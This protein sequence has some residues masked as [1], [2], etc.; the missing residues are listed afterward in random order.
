MHPCFRLEVEFVS[1][2]FSKSLC[3]LA[4]PVDF[5]SENLVWLPTFIN[6]HR[7]FD[8]ANRFMRF[9]RFFSNMTCFLWK[10]SRFDDFS[11]RRVQDSN[12][13]AFLGASGL[14][15]RRNRP[16]LPTLHWCGADSRTRTENFR[17]T[18]AI[19]YHWV[20]SATEDFLEP[21]GGFEPSKPKHWFTKPDL[22]T[23]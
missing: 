18:R 16:T 17:L 7:I 8:F 15:N 22:L 19:L 21:A 10:S 20:K 5:L 6:I 11:W 9:F 13:W 1:S 12:L 14:A 23:T 2:P 3:P 4:S